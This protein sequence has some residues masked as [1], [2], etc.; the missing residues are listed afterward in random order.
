M[1]K[2]LKTLTCI[3]YIWGVVHLL[4]TGRGSSGESH[5]AMTW[6]KHD[7]AD[8]EEERVTSVPSLLSLVLG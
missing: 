5:T 6:G 2:L 7:E 3:L 4:S 8:L 1:R